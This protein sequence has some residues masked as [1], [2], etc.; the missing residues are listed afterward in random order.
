MPFNKNSQLD[1]SQVD[2]RRGRGMGTTVALGGG[3]LGLIILVIALLT[4]VNP[5]DL[6]GAAQQGPSASI[7][8][9]AEISSLADV[10]QTGADA[11]SRKDCEVVGFVNSIQAFWTDEFANQGAE[12]TPARTVLFSGSTEGA[13]GYASA[14]TG[15]FYCPQDQQVYL[16]LA[17]FEQL[18][19]QFGA[20]G[21][22]FAEAYVSSPRVRTSRSGP[23]RC[24][25]HLRELRCDRTTERISAHRITSGLFGRR[26]DF[27]RH[28]NRL[29]HSAN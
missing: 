8:N 7:D 12:Y 3:G 16:D 11:N 26:L 25:G 29:P 5:G 9:P 19:S 14:A 4:G 27:P 23:C 18:Q 20:Q 1:S 6:L 17:F 22:A 2:D 28:R 10:C 15:P 13:C 21:G 24:P